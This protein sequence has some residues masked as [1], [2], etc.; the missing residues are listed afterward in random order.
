MALS[1]T[2]IRKLNRMNRAAQDSN[3]GTLVGA[4]ESK[5][6][7]SGSLLVSAAQSNA[8]A[9]DIATG[10]TGIKWFDIELYRSGSTL[11]GFNVVNSGSN[12]LVSNV[13]S[14]SF[15]LATSDL[16]NWEVI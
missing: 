12:L 9:V 14:A 6:A 1:S 11:S 4:I 15:V 10:V 7:T 5:V 8:S 16:I 13:V 2:V 3:L